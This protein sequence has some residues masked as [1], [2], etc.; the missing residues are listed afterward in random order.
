MKIIFIV[1]KAVLMLIIIICSHIV[2]D[3]VADGV[4][5]QECLGQVC[6]LHLPNPKILIQAFWN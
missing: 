4:D 1:D 2:V 5:G 3:D 6:S